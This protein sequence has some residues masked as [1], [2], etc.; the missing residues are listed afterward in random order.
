MIMLMGRLCLPEGSSSVFGFSRCSLNCSTLS[1]M[2]IR[3]HLRARTSP[4]HGC[5]FLCETL[6]FSAVPRGRILLISSQ[7]AGDR[8]LSLPTEYIPEC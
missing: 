5:I 7:P 8:R 2:R 1:W 4:Q 6:S 3:V